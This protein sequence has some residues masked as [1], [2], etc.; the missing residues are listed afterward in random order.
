MQQPASATHWESAGTRHIGV[1][2]SD[3]LMFQRAAPQTSGADLGQFYGLALPLLLRGMPVEPVQIESA[4][5]RSAQDF[6]RPYQILLLT[7]DGQKPPSPRFHTAL[8]AWVRQ[9]GA[10]I[11]LDD[12]KDPYNHAQDWWNSAGNAFATPRDHLFQTLGLAPSA[13]GLHPVGKGFV[14]YQPDSPASLTH[15]ATGAATVFALLETAAQAIHL[16]LKETGTLVLRRGPYVIAA[17]L[18]Q[19]PGSASQTAAQPVTVRGDLIDLFDA[20]LGESPQITVIPGT[21]ALLLD[22]NFFHSSQPRI[23][24]AS[25]KI[26]NER[27]TPRSLSFQAEGIDQTQAAVR[28]LAVKPPRAVTLDGQPLDAANFQHSGRTLLL[29]FPNT[30]VPQKIEVLF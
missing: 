22:V 23:L 21:R 13:T 19:E 12:G 1:L 10:L 2:V 7:Y 29:R 27:A 18:D 30:A 9:G 3:T 4:C 17:G 15:A 26:T 5:G 11:V 16:P 24:A 6:L 25:A 20:D 14:L 8:A 28:I